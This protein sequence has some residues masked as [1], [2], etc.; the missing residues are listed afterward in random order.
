MGKDKDYVKQAVE[1]LGAK[2]A[3]D[4]AVSQ[5]KAADASPNDLFDLYINEKSLN[6]SK[7]IKQQDASASS[8]AEHLKDVKSVAGKDK[9]DDD[10]T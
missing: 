3:Y 7:F 10:D 2:E 4:A 9:D 6:V 1:F 8:P 5:L